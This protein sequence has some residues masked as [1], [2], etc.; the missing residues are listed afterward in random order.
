MDNLLFFAIY[1]T[2]RPER[3]SN[4]EADD[5]NLITQATTA[6]VHS[7]VVAGVIKRRLRL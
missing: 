3:S 4:L 6:L 5:E 7:A 1:A 2:I